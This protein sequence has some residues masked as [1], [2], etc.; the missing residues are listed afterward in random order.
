MKIL[1]GIKSTSSLAGTNEFSPS[2]SGQQTDVI[3]SG[4]EKEVRTYIKKQKN[5]EG[6][7][8]LE[9]ELEEHLEGSAG[10]AYEAKHGGDAWEDRMYK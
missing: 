5:G 9:K 3:M 7:K 2:I 8:E 4:T 1:L 6:L 10:R